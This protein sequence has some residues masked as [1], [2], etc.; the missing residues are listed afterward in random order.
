MYYVIFLPT[1]NKEVLNDVRPSV[2]YVN[3]DLQLVVTLEGNV[4]EEI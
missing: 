3:V 1:R 2:L 4:T